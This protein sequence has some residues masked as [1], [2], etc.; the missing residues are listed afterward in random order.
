V[1]ELGGGEDELHEAEA[2]VGDFGGA[3]GWVGWV[4]WGEREG[5]G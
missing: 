2:G 5:K 1:V 4:G 3:V